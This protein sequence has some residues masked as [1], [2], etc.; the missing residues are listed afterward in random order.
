MIAVK[1]VM[2]SEI[3]ERKSFGKEETPRSKW[4]KEL[5]EEFQKSKA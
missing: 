5:L 2:L 1:E 3:P 4:A